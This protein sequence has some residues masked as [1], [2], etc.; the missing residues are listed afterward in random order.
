[1]KTHYI[2]FLFSKIYHYQFS[3][4]LLK[5]DN[6]LITNTFKLRKNLTIKSVVTEASDSNASV[7][8]GYGFNRLFNT[9]YLSACYCCPMIKSDKLSNSF[10]LK[11]LL[12]NEVFSNTIN[13]CFMCLHPVKSLVNGLHNEITCKVCVGRVSYSTY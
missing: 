11:P 9:R 6:R 10:L 1:L 7:I 2:T 13:F 5:A 3:D 12:A 4:V 8:V